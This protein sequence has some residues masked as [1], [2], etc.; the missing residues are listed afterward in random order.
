MLV[1]LLAAA[2]LAPPAAFSDPAGD[3]GGAPDVTSVRI[4]AQGSSL[5]VAIRVAG[6][7]GDARLYVPLD[8]DDGTSTG[9]RDG[10]DF[11]AYAEPGGRAELRRWNGS[12]FAA[13][14]GVA[15]AV[16]A[17]DG[18]VE[19]DVPAGGLGLGPVLAFGV[20]AARG[21]D[22]DAVPDNG[23]LRYR[24]AP[25][26]A[27]RFA[28]AAPA[29]G[30]RFAVR[31]TGARQIACEARVGTRRLRGACAWTVPASARGR[32]LVVTV[33]V[34]GRARVYRFRVR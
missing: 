18:L 13:L 17:G 10:V 26:V 5:R 9:D 19:V 21:D 2:A 20:V 24:L 28:P 25:A 15:P 27:V 3:A 34:D 32:R 14:A 31:V 7:T 30:R 6:F 11:V 16:T 8:V 1:E 29:A 23:R 33:R 12:R 22:A 4:E